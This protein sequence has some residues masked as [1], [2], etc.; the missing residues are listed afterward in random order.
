VS[1]TKIERTKKGEKILEVEKILHD[2]QGQGWIYQ[3]IHFGLG[4]SKNLFAC[5][6]FIK[7]Q[8]FKETREVRKE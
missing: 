8:E 4:K 3:S 1:L 6:R 2:N 5:L 7:T